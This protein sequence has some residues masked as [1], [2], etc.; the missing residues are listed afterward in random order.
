MPI[1]AKDLAAARTL[2]ERERHGTLCTAHAAHGG[3]PFGSLVPYALTPEGDPV[4]LLSAIAEHTRNVAAD[5]RV[6]LFVIDSET[7]DHPQA[8]ARIALMARAAPAAGGAAAV[9]E[10]AY[11]A[12]FPESR[13]HFGAHDFALYV[14]RVER[15]RWIAGFGSM[16]WIERPEWSV[17]LAR[18]PIAAYATAILHHM[19]T[20]HGD[21]LLA[22]SRKF[23]GVDAA[24][25]VMTGVD[26]TGFDVNVVPKGGRVAHPVRIAF[27]KPVASPDDVRR[28][29]MDLVK[30][31][32]A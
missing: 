6:T 22:L 25:A 27:P 16:G 23:A 3:W 2:L 19:N 7:I 9:A 32:K 21:S 26:A 4:V 14:L 15:I 11:F 28:A 31:A 29:M 20:D 1:S 13:A 10:T 17:P 5:P 8:G 18:D 12:R 30:S 24:T